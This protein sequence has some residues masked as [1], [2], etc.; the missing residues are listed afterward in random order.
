MVQRTESD[1]LRG[2]AV[3]V[4]YFNSPDTKVKGKLAFDIANVMICQ[5]RMKACQ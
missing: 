1:E 3:E 2:L 5:C 4:K